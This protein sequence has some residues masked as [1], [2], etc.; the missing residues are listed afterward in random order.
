[1]ARKKSQGVSIGAVRRYLRLVGE[2]RCER[3]YV[4][5]SAALAL[6]GRLKCGLA[7]RRYVFETVTAH[8]P[9]G[10]RTCFGIGRADLLS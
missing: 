10:E 6:H 3:A 7:R 4:L 2:K 8:G 5:S 9:F 1:M